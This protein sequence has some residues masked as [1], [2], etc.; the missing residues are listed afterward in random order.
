MKVLLDTN[1]VIHRETNRIQNE[2]IG[3]LFKWL[4]FLKHDKVIHPLTVDEINKYNDKEV[5]RTLNIKLQAYALLQTAAPVHP[6][7]VTKIVPLDRNV[8][9]TNDTL[10]VNEVISDRVAILISED[11]NLHRKAEILSIQDRVFTIESFLKRALVENPTLID[12]RVLSVK[13]TLFGNVNVNDTFFDSFRQDYPGFD[14]WFNKKSEEPVYTAYYG[15]KLAAF[16]Y[17]KVESVGELYSDIEPLFSPKKRM[18][19]GTFKVALIGVGLGERLIKIIFDNALNQRV[20]EIYVTIFLRH[21]GHYMLMRLFEDFGF[22]QWGIKHSTGG[23]ELVLVR[24]FKHEAN[25]LRPKTTFP[26][27][28]KLS[29]IYFVSILPE[30]HTELFPDSILR[31]ESPINF[32]ENQPHRNIIYKSYISHAYE[33]DLNSGDILVFYRTGGVHLGVVSTLAIVDSVVKDL[34][35]FE[36]LRRACRGKTVLTEVQLKKFWNRFPNNK[37]FVV[38]LLY[39]Y[40]L[41]KRINLAKMIELGIFADAFGI[42]RGFGRLTNEHFDL[43]LKHSQA[44]ESIIGD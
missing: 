29:P 35:D 14:K 26:F 18:K 36:Q 13:K 21:P 9:D 22:K 34:Q 31:T 25:R 16:L 6:E 19:I 44:D 1:I 33:R 20:D 15:K 30:Y 11:K 37:P 4:E 10:L 27:L 39:A 17:L 2:E 40:S 24:D 28:S 3:Q 12:Y 43:I 7:V 5:L 38:N 32:T 8:N 42:P 23:D 41:P